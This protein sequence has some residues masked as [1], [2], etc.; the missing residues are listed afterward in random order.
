[1]IPVKCLPS[2][3]VN[4]QCILLQAL[5][6]SNLPR[7]Q[8]ELYKEIKKVSFFLSCPFEI[9]C[10]VTVLIYWDVALVSIN[11]VSLLRSRSKLHSGRV[12]DCLFY[13]ST[14]FLLLAPLFGFNHSWK[15]I[16]QKTCEHLVWT[17]VWVNLSGSALKWISHI[18]D[19]CS[20]D[21]AGKSNF[22]QKGGEK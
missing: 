12:C 10:L 6:D 5:M 7:L 8:L 3:T 1:M 17:A 14:Q 9:W 15:L 20:T 22:K 19:V 16:W 11:H 18:H 2:D 13:D 21:W 4:S